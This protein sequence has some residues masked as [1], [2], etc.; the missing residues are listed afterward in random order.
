MLLKTEL[1]VI[2]GGIQLLNLNVAFM[3]QVNTDEWKFNHMAINVAIYIR[4]KII[5]L[6]VS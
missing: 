2:I 6:P 5:A 4:K 3:E 1:I